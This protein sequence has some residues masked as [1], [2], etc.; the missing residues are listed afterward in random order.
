MALRKALLLFLAAYFTADTVINALVS[1][2][3]KTIVPSKSGKEV[4]DFFATPLNWPNIVLSSW[5]VKGTTETPLTKGDKVKECFGLPPIVPLSVEWTCVNYKSDSRGG[6]LDVRAKNGVQ[7]LASD[8]RMLFKIEKKETATVMVDLIVEYEPQ[9]ALGRVAW[10]VLAVDNYMALNLFFP[11]EL[12]KKESWNRLDQFRDLMGTLYGA[13]G[14]AH[15]ADCL[16]GPSTIMVT[17]GC[18]AFED[19]PI[20]GQLLA[21][22]WCAMGPFS[23]ILT[24]KGYADTGILS[25]GVFEVVCA[26][27]VSGVYPRVTLEGSSANIL[28]NAVLVQLIVGATW[29]YTFTKS[30]SNSKIF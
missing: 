25:Y 7:G 29:L 19:L 18:P 17:S 22:M 1:L 15:F 11:S 2:R 20:Q 30:D 13:A 26:A 21:L 14:V 9:S 28:E 23:Y 6:L 27:I 8:C 24:K 10:P 5:D 12:R 16:L 4:L 3:S